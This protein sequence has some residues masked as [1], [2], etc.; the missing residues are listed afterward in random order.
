MAEDKPG[1]LRRPMKFLAQ[2]VHFLNT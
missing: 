1:N 2:N